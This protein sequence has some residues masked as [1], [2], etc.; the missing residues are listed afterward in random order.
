MY[1]A[2]N[3][4]WFAQLKAKNMLSAV[5]TKFFY[6]AK[7]TRALEALWV[8]PRTLLTNLPNKA[9][10]LFQESFWLLQKS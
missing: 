3:S 1:H 10:S 5:L 6:K 9:L 8:L 7:P 2:E 4:L